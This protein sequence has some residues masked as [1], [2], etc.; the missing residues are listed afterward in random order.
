MF[1][2]LPYRWL[3]PTAEIGTASVVRDSMIQID[4]G[5]ALGPFCVQGFLGRGAFAQV[6]LAEDKKGRRVALKVGDES[7]GGRY[8]ARFPE[9]TSERAPTRVSPDET[10]AE[11][12][13]LHPQDGP[14][15]EVLDAAEVDGL[16]YREADLL[17]RAKGAGTVRLM[18]CLDINGRPVLALEYLQGETLRE[19]MRALKGV[20]LGW[21]IEIIRILEHLNASGAWLCHG[22]LKPE[23]IVVTPEERVVLVDPAPEVERAEEIIATPAYNPFLMQNSKGDTHSIAIMVYELLCGGLPF[24]EVPWRYSGCDPTYFSAEELRLDRSFFLGYPRPRELNP[25]TPV[26][27]EHAIYSA[28]CDNNYT[29]RDLRLDLEDFLMRR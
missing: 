4:T 25:K 24:E 2:C 27:V 12:L 14:R 13:F 7:G 9:V 17:R 10:P 18:D 22:D 1:G 28:M 5:Q 11:A 15:V 21:I 20:K 16:L 29:L 6:F 8:L 3:V 23:N 19:R 26:E